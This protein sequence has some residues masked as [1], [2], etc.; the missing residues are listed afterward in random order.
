MLPE[1]MTTKEE[2]KSLRYE[3]MSELKIAKEDLKT[4][5]KSLHSKMDNS[6]SELQE[7]IADLDNVQIMNLQERV[8]ELEGFHPVK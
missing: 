1:E 3:M 6:F 5:I 7:Q 4:D 2:L 8:Q